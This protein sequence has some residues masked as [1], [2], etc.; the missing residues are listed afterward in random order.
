[1]ASNLRSQGRQN[2]GDNV[3]EGVLVSQE[4]PALFAAYLADHDFS[5]NSGRAFTQDVRKFAGWFNSANKEP[6]RLER[7]TTRDI[8]DFRDH[9]RREQG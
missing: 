2:S 3:F 9:L 1:M 7:V 6:F 4:E 8:T 5:P